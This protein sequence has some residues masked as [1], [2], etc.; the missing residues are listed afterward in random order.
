MVEP[1]RKPTFEEYLAAERSTEERHDYLAGEVF[2][3]GGASRRHNRLVTNLILALGPQ[4]RQRGCEIYANDMRVRVDA[5]D[6]AAYPDVVIACGQPRFT[7]GR[8][9]TLLDPTVLVEVL[10]PSTA[11]YDRGRKFASYRAL[12]SLR[13]YLLVAQDRVHVEHFSHQADGSWRLQETTDPTA[14]LDLP[15]IACRLDL[16]EVYEGLLETS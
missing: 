9:D 6:F 16:Q 4:L 8:Q 10:S 14:T 13:D 15:S 11:D 7:D 3:M 5:A 1:Q 12:P 2:A